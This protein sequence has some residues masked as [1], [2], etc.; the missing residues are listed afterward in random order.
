MWVQVLVLVTSAGYFLVV[1]ERN[2]VKYFSIDVKSLIIIKYV[3]S[4]FGG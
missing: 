2:R 4:S 3:G 1:A